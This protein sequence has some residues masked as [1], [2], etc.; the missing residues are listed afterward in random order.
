MLFEFLNMNIFSSY[1]MTRIVL[2]VK[3]AHGEP[4]ECVCHAYQMQWESFGSSA[5]MT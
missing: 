4:N 1:L 5:D 2:L 3:R